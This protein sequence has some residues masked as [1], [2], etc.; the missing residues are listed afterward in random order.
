MRRT[1]PSQVASF[2]ER[3]FPEI[4]ERANEDITMLLHT[5]SAPKLTTLVDLLDAVPDELLPES[6]TDYENVLIARNLID[7]RLKRWAANADTNP[8]GNVKGVVARSPVALILTTLRQC[9]DERPS[10]NA[11]R[12]DF[13][14]DPELAASIMLDEGAASRALALGEW[15]TATVLAGSAIEALLLNCLQRP[16]VFALITS[17]GIAN[18]A[19]PA[20]LERWTLDD[21][22]TAA[23]RVNAIEPRTVTQ[24]RLAKDFRN[25]IHPGRA[26][27]LGQRCDRGTAFG[28]MSALDFVVN[29]IRRHYD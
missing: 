14:A 23:E 7:E 10:P 4:A 2:I 19:I 11:T 24:A 9:P 5:M 16:A 3:A 15:K 13:L 28:A 20:A 12:L 27:R 25:L 1:V 22:I 29:D 6:A 17:A 26:Q 21:L 8:L 18:A